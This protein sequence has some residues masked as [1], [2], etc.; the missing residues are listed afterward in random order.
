MHEFDGERARRAFAE[1]EVALLIDRA[2]MSDR[3]TR[4][5]PVGVAPLPGSD[6]VFDPNRQRWEDLESPN[7]PSYLPKG[8]GWL[9]GVSALSKTGT[10]EAA[11]DF[12]KYLVG[13]DLANSIR[14]NSS[15]PTLPVRSTA[16]GAGPVGSNA[17]DARQWAD[18]VG[19]TL[20]AVRVVPGLRIPGADGYLSDLAAGRVAALNG[21]PAKAALEGVAKAWQERTQRLGTARQAWHYQRSLNDLVTT[22]E[23]PPR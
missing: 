12:A 9:V 4:K 22:S 10:R 17:V 7:A 1:G 5:T 8:G 15:F 19:R 2:E 16:L 21:Q 6:R 14:S 18:A 23:P 11:I 13:P 3:W 20:A